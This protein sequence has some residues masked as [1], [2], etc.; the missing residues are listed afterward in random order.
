MKKIFL[1]P[2]VLIFSAITVSAN[3]NPD[4]SVGG[5]P[6]QLMQQQTFQKMEIHDYMRFKDAN[7]MPVERRLD[8]PDKIQ[9]EFEIKNLKKPAKI[10]LRTQQQEA[11]SSQMEMV[12]DNGKI[13]IKPIED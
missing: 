10:Q 9:A 2:A 3:P 13:H 11:P 4:M 5:M 7:E 8:G 1:I 12:E 6:F